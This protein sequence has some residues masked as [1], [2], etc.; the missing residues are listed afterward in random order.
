MV[1]HIKSLSME[2]ETKYPLVVNYPGI[3]KK[4]LPV[5][6]SVIDI[7]SLQAFLADGTEDRIYSPRPINM[8]CSLLMFTDAA[9]I[10]ELTRD[11]T[12]VYS[13]SVYPSWERIKEIVFDRMEITATKK[14]NVHISLSDIPDGSP[15]IIEASYIEGNPYVYRGA[16]PVPAAPTMATV[17][18]DVRASLG[19]NS[20]TGFIANMGT[21]AG[22]L[23]I[24]EDAGDGYTSDYYTVV[25]DGVE[26]LS[27]CNIAKLKIG[28]TVDDTTF[29]LNFR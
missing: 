2:P 18:I 8:A 9:I 29:E 3:G 22:D 27:K 17:E 12:T 7:K 14:T 15:D 28:A 20:Q 5:G 25:R 16:V 1:S 11:G 10:V 6:T 23:Y 21:T 26:N 4:D 19:R 24:Y 13:S